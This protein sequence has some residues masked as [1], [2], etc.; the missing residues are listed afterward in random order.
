MSSPRKFNDEET[1]QNVQWAFIHLR[2]RFPIMACP[3][4]MP[5]HILE[6]GGWPHPSRLPLGAG[7]N[8]YCCAT[9][10]RVEPT[11]D[12]LRDFCNLGY[13]GKCTRLPKEKSSE[14]VRFS[15]VRDRGTQLTLMFVHE[16]GHRPAGHG[17]LE[18]DVTGKR[19]LAPHPDACT[20]R[21]AECYLE[22]YSARQ[23]RQTTAGTPRL[24]NL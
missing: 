10:T 14:A 20:Q 4:F 9:T 15:V 16:N 24:V 2:L 5:T 11:A 12:E 7:W 3:F 21:M 23:N 17:T 19:W 18:Y 8:G 6:N 13:A 22:S 1:K